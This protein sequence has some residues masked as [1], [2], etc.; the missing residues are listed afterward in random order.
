VP[1]D[2]LIVLGERRFEREGSEGR[3]RVPRAPTAAFMRTVPLPA[4]VRSDKS[5][6]R[7]GVLRV[8]LPKRASRASS[9]PG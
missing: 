6:Y 7:A 3:S 2:A 5:R 8:E 4:P 9:S 1:D